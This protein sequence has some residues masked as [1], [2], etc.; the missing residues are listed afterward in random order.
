VHRFLKTAALLA[1]AGLALSG[2]IDS[3]GPI[4]SDSQQAFGPRLHV[5]LF[6]L[7]NGYA[8]DPEQAVFVWRGGLYAHAAGALREV[9]AFSVNPFENG[10]FIIQEVPTKRPRISEY[11]LLHKLADGVYQV[12]PIDENDAD[13]STRAA[14]CSKGSPQDPSA[15]R[16]ETRA[17]L[18]AFARA[19]AARGK[20]DGG[21]AI[22]LPAKPER[23][24]RH[25]GRHRR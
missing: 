18:I 8:H 25:R 19:T 21:L 20:Q 15:C 4:L 16:I 7:R 13:E 17:Q 11:A 23:P 12:L 5:Q 2:C 1:V 14:Y 24:E 6:T 9:S 22:L 3:S 10:D